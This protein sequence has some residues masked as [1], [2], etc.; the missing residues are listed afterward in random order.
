MG[1]IK[2][3]ACYRPNFKHSK[4]P[5]NGTKKQETWHKHPENLELLALKEMKLTAF[6]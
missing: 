6:L 5:S 1:D 2:Q 4:D 3:K